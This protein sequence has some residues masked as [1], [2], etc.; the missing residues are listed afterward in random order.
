MVDIVL[1]SAALITDE[2]IVSS[3]NAG[4]DLVTSIDYQIEKFLIEQ[5]NNKY[6][7]YDIVSEEFNADNK[8][9][10]NCFVIDPLDGTINFAH[11]LPLWGIQMCQVSGGMCQVAVIHLPKLGELYFANKSGAYRVKA[12][13]RKT[14]KVHN[15]GELLSKAERIQVSDKPADKALYLVEGGNKFPA[16]ARLNKASRHW[17]YI[18]C[19]AVNSAWTACGR[20][21]G[22][23]LRKDNVWD[24]LP[25]QYLVQQAGG[26]IINKKGAHIAANSTELARLLLR[27]G[28]V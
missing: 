11:G 18:C 7:D 16:L 9:T 14:N 3:K 12:N 19:T 20:L 13:F 26:V 24:Y 23:I 5:I 28:K 6:P 17:R 27:D 8:L 15:V 10:E 2:F 1:R 25:G 21:G 22:T 4:G